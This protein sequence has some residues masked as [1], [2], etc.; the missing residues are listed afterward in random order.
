MKKTIQSFGYA[1]HGI[2]TVF[3][4]ELNMRIHLVVAVLVII[5]GVAF[6]ISLTE[7]FLCLLCFGLVISMEMMNTAIEK[8]VD[9]VSPNHH[10]I[11]GKVKD[12]AAGAVLICAIISAI[13][14]LLIFG[15]KVWSFFTEYLV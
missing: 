15:P 5:S 13:V 10:P 14:G 6:M 3:Q 4:S 11:A 2:R 1:G 9:L 12:V 7:W 8:L